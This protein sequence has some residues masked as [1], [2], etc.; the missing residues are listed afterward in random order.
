VS[1]GDPERE[2][3]VDQ[4]LVDLDVQDGDAVTGGSLNAYVEN[5]TGEKQGKLKG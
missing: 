4:V 1:V 2:E 5:V 3:P